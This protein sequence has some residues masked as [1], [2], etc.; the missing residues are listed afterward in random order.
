MKVN[1]CT[2]HELEIVYKPKFHRENL[3]KITNSLGAANL[4]RKSYN[5]NTI[6][7]QEEVVV[8]FLDIANQVIGV[9]KLS[10]GGMSSTLVDIRLLLSVA[11]KCLASGII[12]SHNHPSG[13][14][15]PS[16]TDRTMTKQLK[17]ACK[18]LEIILL[19]HIILAPGSGYYS[20]TDDSTL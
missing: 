17:K 8:L 12:L 6:E 16:D 18:L 19:D 15:V 4:L 3:E 7:C 20:F 5:E 9:Q 11:L 14:L 13:K 2:V 1:E 10:K